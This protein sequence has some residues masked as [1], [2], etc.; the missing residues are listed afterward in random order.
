MDNKVRISIGNQDN[1]PLNYP[2]RL[3]EKQMKELNSDFKFAY[4]PGDHFTVFSRDYRK[5]G[6]QFLKQ[7]YLEWLAKSKTEKN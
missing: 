6:N 4:Y 3:L 2:V 7:K 1:F 5:E